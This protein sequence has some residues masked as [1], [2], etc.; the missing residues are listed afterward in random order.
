MS[1]ALEDDTQV[2]ATAMLRTTNQACA[3]AHPPAAGG[4]PLP[5]FA[6]HHAFFATDQPAIQLAN[7]ASQSYGSEDVT[8]PPP[9]FGQ[10]LPWFLQ[11][12]TFFC[13][14]HPACPMANPSA[15]L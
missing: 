7:P 13:T 3:Q 14:D 6:Q 12:Q 2:S 8:P 15:Q 11:H 5:L 10:P 9:E 4:Q 1:M